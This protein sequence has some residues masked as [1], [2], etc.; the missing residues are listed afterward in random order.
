[1]AYLTWIFQGSAFEGT[2]RVIGSSITT[3]AKAARWVE[4]WEQK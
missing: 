4:L 2:Y 1:M 3:I